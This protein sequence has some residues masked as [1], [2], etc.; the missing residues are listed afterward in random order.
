MSNKG[1]SATDGV[2]SG[3]GAVPK[4]TMGQK[5]LAALPNLQRQPAPSSTSAAERPA[6]APGPA[7]ANGTEETLSP[8]EVISAGAAPKGKLRDA[9]L[10]PPARRQQR[11]APS[12]MSKEE[13]EHVIKRIDDRER[14]LAYSSAGLGVVVGVVLTIA[15]VHYYAPVHAKDHEST[16]FIL[17][18][19]S[20]RLVLAAVVIL[21]AW[22]RRRSFVA[23]A[24]LFLGTSLGFPFALPFWA[25]GIWMI[26]RV[27]RWQ[28]ELAT[29]TGST[30]RNRPAPA[31]RGRDAA[32]ARRKARNEGMARRTAG[33]RR[34]KKEPE[35]SGP[36]QN[37]R[38]TP[39]RPPRQRP[40]MP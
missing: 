21:A 37:K 22:K 18:E 32:E 30:A 17:F 34:K 16:G 24:L 28:K 11:G 31:A 2:S 27:L 39:P 9:F 13:L 3:N 29:L 10:K 4:L 26:F 20:A 15:A 19:G 25:L 36:P 33:G 35:P 8:D 40:G 23:F 5:V 1:D 14:L 6:R 12:G 7:R 38:Y